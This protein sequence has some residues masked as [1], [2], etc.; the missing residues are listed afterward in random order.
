VPD[1]IT[2]SGAAISRCDGQA[3]P[4]GV[5][6]R[7]R[8]ATPCHCAGWSH[9]ACYPQLGQRCPRHKQGLHLLPAGQCHAIAPDVVTYS[10]AASMC[11]RARSTSGPCISYERCYG[12]SS[13]RTWSP[14]EPP[15]GQQ[16]Q[17]ALRLE[18]AM[19]SHGNAPEVV[20]GC[21]AISWGPSASSTSRPYISYLRG[22]AMPSRRR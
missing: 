7:A 20:T 22:R 18:R 10:A 4:A 19:R 8:D 12:M 5:T 11:R 16:Y 9:L 6:S 14:T 21:A 2:Y 3:V 13:C 17:Q 1:V 15:L